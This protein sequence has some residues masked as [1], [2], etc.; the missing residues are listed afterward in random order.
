MLIVSKHYRESD[1][2][3][4]LSEAL[5]KIICGSSLE[6]VFFCV[7]SDRHLLDSFGPLTGSMIKEQIPGAVVCGTLDD[8][9][10]A[11]NLPLK[12]KETQ[13]DYPAS[14]KIAI[15]ASLGMH[16]EIGFINL[17][18]GSLLPGK[19]VAHRLPPIGDY[20]L[21][22]VVGTYSH[23]DGNRVREPDGLAN[24]YHLSQLVSAAVVKCCKNKTNREG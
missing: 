18:Q 20:A 23:K 17:R 24:I 5:E 19:A 12:V 22:G 14:I 13:N 16:G 4:V 2:L 7:G 21:T 1:A 3:I 8:P 10:H 11:R 15:D 6:P 9:L